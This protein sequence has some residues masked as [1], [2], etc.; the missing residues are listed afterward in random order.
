[1]FMH[2]LASTTR[3]EAEDEATEQPSDLFSLLVRASEDAGGKMGLSDDELIGNIFS[4]PINHGP[5]WAAILAI[6]AVKSDLQDELVA[7]VQE[8]ARGRD[9]D[10]LVNVILRNALLPRTLRNT[11]LSWWQI[12]GKLDE[13]LAAFYEGT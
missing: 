2:T 1:M 7:Q 4:F 8:V 10:T 12:T 13:G 11:F 3:S 9:D 5:H 6:L